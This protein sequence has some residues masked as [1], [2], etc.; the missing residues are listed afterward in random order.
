MSPTSPNYFDSQNG[1]YY[2]YSDGEVLVDVPRE[3]ISIL[4][5][6]GLTTLASHTK[7]NAQNSDET[8]INLEEIWNPENHGYKSADFH[9]HLNY[10]GPFRRVVKD[11]G[12]LM[13]GENL[14]IAT[15]VSYTHLTLPTT[16]QV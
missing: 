6:G 10:D 15:P 5:S 9:L 13:E 7:L 8:I 16:V 3:E 11:I 1:S 12:P 4:A 2:F 14:D